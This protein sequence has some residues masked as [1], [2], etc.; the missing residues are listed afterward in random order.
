MGG[1]GDM[2]EPSEDGS[3]ESQ[4][5]VLG[6]MGSPPMLE[7]TLEMRRARVLQ[8][9]MTRLTLEDEQVEESCG[10]AGPAASS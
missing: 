3:M 4:I 1:S 6:G 8:A 7:E 10:T 5:H 2:Y 9:T